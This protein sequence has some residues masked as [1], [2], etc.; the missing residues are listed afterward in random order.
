MILN[1]LV[2]QENG[3]RWCGGYWEGRYWFPLGWTE[4]TSCDLLCTHRVRKLTPTST[5][6]VEST[7]KSA[8][9]AIH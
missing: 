5:V 1:L 4:R 6:E 8:S 2:T 3:K 9:L 7:D